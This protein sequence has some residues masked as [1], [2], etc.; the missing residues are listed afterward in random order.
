MDK[1]DLENKLVREWAEAQLEADLGPDDEDAA[2]AEQIA[3]AELADE[4]ER[5][6]PLTLDAAIAEFHDG[7]PSD[8][9]FDVVADA[10]YS[11]HDEERNQRR[12]YAFFTAILEPA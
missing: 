9:A 11:R 6:A 5:I 4:L 8:E 3:A 10:Y 12:P 7:K 1:D 2:S